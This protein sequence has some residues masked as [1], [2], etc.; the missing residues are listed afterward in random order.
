MGGYWAYVWPSYGLAAIVLIA[1][2]ASAFVQ[3]RRLLAG[4]ARKA[5]RERRYP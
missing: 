5:R 2:A 3:R 4:L 1:V